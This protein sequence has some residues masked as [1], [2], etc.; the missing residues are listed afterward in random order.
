MPNE[1]TTTFRKRAVTG[2]DGNSVTVT[3]DETS[4]LIEIRQ[5]R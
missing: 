3:F 2:A 5:G 1:S 4:N